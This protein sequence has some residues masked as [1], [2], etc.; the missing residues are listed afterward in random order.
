ME[1]K[2]GTSENNS[3]KIK[4]FDKKKKCETCGAAISDE[5][6]S[7]HHCGQINKSPIPEKWWVWVLIFLILIGITGFIGDGF[8]DTPIVE[9]G[10]N[11]IGRS[12]TQP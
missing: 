9:D 12:S 6:K 4:H 1:N 3:F 11:K 7:C 5:S 2:T 8:H 10:Q